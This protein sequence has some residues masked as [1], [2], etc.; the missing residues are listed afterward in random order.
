MAALVDLG[1]DG[2][3]TNVPRVARGVVDGGAAG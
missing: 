2:I 3:C 1:V